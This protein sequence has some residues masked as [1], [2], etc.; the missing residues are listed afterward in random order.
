MATDAETFGTDIAFK[1]DFITTASGDLDK[2][3]GL[4]NFKEAILRRLVTYPGSLIHRP[5]Y[6]VG[7]QKYLGKLNSLSAKQSLAKNIQDQ[8]QEDPRTEAVTGV[9]VIETDDN[10][11][12][13]VIIVR[14]KPIGYD[15]VAIS[16][17][18]FSEAF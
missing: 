6:G 18:P 14:V 4:A 10:P 1:A 13:L 2:V 16:L 9:Q 8:I 12:R 5:T 3:T 7:I 15:E 11:Y 17:T